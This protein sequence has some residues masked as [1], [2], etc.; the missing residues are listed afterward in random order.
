MKG[1]VL[2]GGGTKGAYQLGAYKALKELGIEFDGI[3][4]TS[5]GALNAAFLVQGDFETMQ[6]IWLNRD[7]RSFMDIEEDFYEKYKNVEFKA[8]DINVVINLMNKAR[9]NEGI[10][11][12]PLKNL[13]KENIDEEKIR[14]SSKDFGLVTVYL[15]KKIVPQ[16]LMKEDIPEGKLVD[17]LIASSSLPIFQLEKFEDKRYLDGFLSDNTPVGLLANK[18]YDDIIVIR[19]SNDVAGDKNLQKYADLKLTV[20]K[21]SMVLGGSLNKDKDHMEKLAK[22]GYMDTMKVFKRYDGVKYYFNADFIYDE[23]TC[24]NAIT[25][26]DIKTIEDICKILK[27]KREPSLRVLLEEI[28]PQLGE[29]LHLEKEFTY[30]DIFYSIYERKL[31]E[32]NID[33]LNLYDFSK[34][35]DLV[36][37]KI[38]P[39]D[40]D[41]ENN[42]NKPIILLNKKE[43]NEKAII[44]KLLNDFKN[45]SLRKMP[46]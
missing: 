26:I 36:N 12:T 27:I 9:K 25:N 24:F 34:V 4:G 37:S 1:L 30:K 32:N 16:H 19:L 5:I 20:I 45:Q 17:Y 15:D 46:I 22:L 10:D 8:K 14:K 43:K 28:V 29:I 18:G 40:Y 21:P 23:E 2:E 3:V 31:E 35:I 13:L 44:N 7:Y 11:I 6:D 42:D 33:V 39:I 41:Y 38:E